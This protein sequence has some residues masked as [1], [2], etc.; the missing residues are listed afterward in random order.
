VSENPLNLA[1]RFIL[2]IAGLAAYGYWGWAAH[3]GL[4]RWLLA[5]GAPLLAATLWAVFRVPGDGG[6]PVVAVSGAVRL[7]LE[8]VY[9]GGATWALYA[10]G[11][12]SAAFVFGVAV[13]GHYAISW[14][15]IVR[16]LKG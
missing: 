8:A 11:A 2:E 5:V 6:P 9:F 14:D 15:R 3:D 12:P 10:A 7:V 13:V 4:L 16:F 1:L